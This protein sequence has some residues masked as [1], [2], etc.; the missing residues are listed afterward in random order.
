MNAREQE[1]FDELYKVNYPDIYRY[2]RCLLWVRAN[3]ADVENCVQEVFIAAFESLGKL[4]AMGELDRKVWL[5]SVAKK[6]AFTLNR[7]TARENAAQ[8]LMGTEE[9]AACVDNEISA[10]NVALWEKEEIR[11]EFMYRIRRKLPK[12]SQTLFD[13]LY[14]YGLDESQVST[15]LCLNEDAFRMR[16][17]R[18]LRKI[19]KIVKNF[20][21]F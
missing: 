20:K 19:E 14:I 5:L 3:T 11:R 16:K 7:Q 21:N 4:E 8:M 2:V 12:K 10:D 1:F 15:L 17:V 9:V 13:Y 18:L 6:K